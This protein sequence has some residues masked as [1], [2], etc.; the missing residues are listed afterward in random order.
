MRVLRSN[1]L[2]S[3]I[4][5][6]VLLA[7]S[8]A[9]AIL[10]GALLTFDWMSS[11]AL[12]EKRLSTLADV[13]GQ[14]STAALS[15]N[16]HEA[17]VEV[18]DA[19]HSEPPIVSAC[20]YDLSDNL[21]AQY[22]RDEEAS[23]CPGR[24]TL[25]QPAD[26]GHSRVVRTIFRRDEALGTLAL[27]SDRKELEKNQ[28]RL[29]WMAA[30]LT[31]IALGIGGG[32]GLIL[33]RRV[34]KPIFDLAKAMRKVTHRQNFT[35]RVE[36]AGSDEIAQLGHGFNAMIAELER[37]DA[38]RRKAKE[39][40]QMQA[41]T[42]AL[43]GLPNRR[44]FSDR[45]EQALTLAQKDGHRV[46]L[47]YIDLDGF[48]LINDSLG[49]MIGDI[50]L[51]E[52]ATRL[53]GRLGPGNTLARVGGDEF[54]VILSDLQSKEE[55][56][57]VAQ[58][59]L[60]SLS[61][62]FFI[63]GHEISIGAS[64]GISILPDDSAESSD[65][66]RQADNAMYE[67]KRSGKNQAMF[68]RPELGLMARERLNLENLLR[69]AVGRGEIEVHYQP[70][71][72]SETGRL[73]RFEALARWFHPSLGSIPPSKFIPIAEENGMIAQLGAYVMQKACEEA[74]RWQYVVPYPVQVAVNVSSLQFNDESIVDE[75]AAVLERTKLRPELLQIELTESM[76]IGCVERSAQTMRALRNLGVS[77]AID[78]FG[79]GYSCLSYLPS[80]PF[81][82]IK[83]DRSFVEDLDR[84]K[85]VVAMVR[86]LI[87]LARNMGMRVIVE[88]IE[89]PS[90]LALIRKLGADEVQGF[91]LGRPTAYPMAKLAQFA[92][93]APLKMDDLQEFK[94][95]AH[96]SDPKI[97]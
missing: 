78:D 11:T 18:L 51:Q 6:V 52:V 76:M 33:Q 95:L 77:L 3:N 65:L 96:M 8:V 74:F 22:R 44:L 64:I 34:S 67:A 60:D 17:A 97:R 12:L 1:S 53:Q 90:Q 80:L 93:D 42:D 5:T 23:S 39:E 29:L 54:T 84:R 2:A 61:R 94:P 19:L 20:L 59:L 25:L 9:L 36:V 16:D 24:R 43:T 91:L 49:H 26:R 48:K 66:L 41:R 21:F 37:R 55:S 79:T 14:N 10:V 57:D 4:T 81:Q 27:T 83:I 69:G 56:S 89:E 38:E 46:A 15:F 92:H 86:S 85:Q 32:S 58:D 13:V 35:A 73:V 28:V 45:L 82:A 50:L 30:L 62:P 88:G 71:F 87:G 68:F 75:V 40:L 47:L 7:S 70:E 72:D 31:L 63:E